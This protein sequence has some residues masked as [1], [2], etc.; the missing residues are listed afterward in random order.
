MEG[1]DGFET[2]VQMMENLDGR[3]YFGS[4]GVVG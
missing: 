1:L 3:N 4:T 2:K